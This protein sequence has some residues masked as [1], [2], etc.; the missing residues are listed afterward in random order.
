MF[1]TRILVGLAA[2]AIAPF[3]GISWAGAHYDIGAKQ[4]CPSTRVKHGHGY[5]RADDIRTRG[6]GCRKAMHWIKAGKGHWTRVPWRNCSLHYRDG[7][8]REMRTSHT[9]Y[10]CASPNRR[11]AISWASVWS[12]WS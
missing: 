1:W 4:K 9:D 6:I 7:G 2:A 3:F 5:V 10:R 8:D 11:Q 12:A